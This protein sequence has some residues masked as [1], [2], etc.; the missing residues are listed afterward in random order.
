VLGLLAAGLFASKA[1]NP[2]G[3]DGLFFGNPGQLGI[4]LI[5]VIVTLLY[6]FVL[7]YLFLKI[8]DRIFGLRVPVNDEINGLD[9]SQ[10]D[11]KAYI[12]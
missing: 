7:T 6:A 9:L 11:E 2:N 3:P 8:I 4:Q 10:H 1:V 5:A 12:L